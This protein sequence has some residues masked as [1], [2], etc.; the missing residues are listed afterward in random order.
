MVSELLIVGPVVLMRARTLGRVVILAAIALIVATGLCLLD[1]GGGA[2]QDLCMILVALAPDALPILGLILTGALAPA[3][4][5][6]HRPSL[7]DLPVPPPR[8]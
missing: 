2:G 6:V 5:G 3:L 1:A 8:A 7:L 4:V